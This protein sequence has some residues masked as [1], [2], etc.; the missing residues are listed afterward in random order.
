MKVPFTTV[1]FLDIF[2]QYNETVYPIQPVIYLLGIIAVF[3]ALKPRTDSD[4]RI[5]MILSFLWLWMGIVYHMVFFSAINNAAWLFGTLFIVQGL[6]FL[7]YGVL[8]SDLSFKFRKDI[9]G[10]TGLIILLYA[11][12]IYPVWGY[13]L[14]HIYPES[15]TFGVPCPTTIFT[16]GLL[17]MSDR[18]VRLSL[19]II[20]VLW[21]V[22]GFSAAFQFGIIEDTG[23]IV[24][25][26][27][28]LV[29]VIIR[30]RKIATATT[31]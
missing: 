12:L 23:L 27:L 20:P 19:L 8:Q 15:P 30:N 21:S 31:L 17:L 10:L 6:L 4:K 16:F 1:E 5:G 2:R 3:L 26:M 13:F 18:K 11:M 29:L 22:I 14:N 7:N 24:T 25:A 28:T 9:Y